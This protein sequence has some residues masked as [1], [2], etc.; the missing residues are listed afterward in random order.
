MTQQWIFR[1]YQYQITKYQLPITLAGGF[2]VWRLTYNL[3]VLLAKQV[4]LHPTYII[5]MMYVCTY[6]CKL[7][8]YTLHIQ[9]RVLTPYTESQR[10]GRN[11][12]ARRANSSLYI[13]LCR[14]DFPL[15][16]N[17]GL[18]I[19]TVR[20]RSEGERLRIEIKKWGWVMNY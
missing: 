16:N 1:Y 4:Y 13:V 3:C 15:K 12:E 5:Y 20:I 6:D 18:K 11:K 2:E 10:Y 9:N 17:R 19:F 7:Q 8:R 14:Q